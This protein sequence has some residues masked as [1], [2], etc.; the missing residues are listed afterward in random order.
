MNVPPLCIIQARWDSKRLPGK[1]L[2]K[3]GD[4]TLI[5]R[6]WRI[7]C[8]AF[9]ESNCVVATPKAENPLIEELRRIGAVV[10]QWA[11][12]EWDVLSRLYA[13]AHTYRWHPDSV[14][15]RYTPDDP[16]K[17]VEALR[18]PVIGAVKVV[19]MKLL[20]GVMGC[21]YTKRRQH[22][23]PCNYRATTRRL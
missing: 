22:E 9:G 6:A 1:M 5:T 21:V 19:A 14:I 23:I 11:G 3:L 20:F 2:L 13:C 10:F 8:E 15:V 17:S 18:P 12:P 16:F 4:E 7:A